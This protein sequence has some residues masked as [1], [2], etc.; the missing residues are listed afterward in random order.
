M[1]CLEFHI[2]IFL[3]KYNIY[4]ENMKNLWREILKIQ[5]LVQNDTII[6]YVYIKF[7]DCA[8]FEGKVTLHRVEQS[9]IWDPA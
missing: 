1:I 6:F 4:V 8:K 7:E 2:L 5:Y 3:R 9:A